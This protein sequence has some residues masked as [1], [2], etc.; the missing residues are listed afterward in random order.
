M[1]QLYSFYHS[2]LNLTYYHKFKKQNRFKFAIQTILN[3]KFYRFTI[4]LN[5]I[6]EQWSKI[7]YTNTFP[8][9][10]RNLTHINQNQFINYTGRN[11]LIH[12]Y[13][14]TKE[15]SKSCDLIKSVLLK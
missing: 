14:I 5:C 4:N 3:P 15:L 11:Y 12:T 13:W 7:I 6:N 1:N 9:K 2:K 8:L 10:L